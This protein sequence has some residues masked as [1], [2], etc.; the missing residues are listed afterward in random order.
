M[1]LSCLSIVLVDELSFAF[2]TESGEGVSVH[3]KD[4]VYLDESEAARNSVQIQGPSVA[5]ITVMCRPGSV[6][7]FV[8][9]LKENKWNWSVLVQFWLIFLREVLFLDLC[10]QSR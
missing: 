1:D 10:L 6:S 5:G 2:D 9:K 7:F 8:L 4:F 3:R